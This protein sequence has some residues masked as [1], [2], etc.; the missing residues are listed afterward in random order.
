MLNLA[1]LVPPSTL[2]KSTLLLLPLS[3][4]IY[5]NITKILH[6]MILTIP[7]GFSEKR[8][9]LEPGIAEND[10]FIVDGGVLGKGDPQ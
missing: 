2:S 6:R 3:K 9:K 10:R 5:K 1:D 8:K 7:I 4:T